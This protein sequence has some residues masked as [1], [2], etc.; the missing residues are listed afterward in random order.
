[1][2]TSGSTI[3]T[4]N[5]SEG[6]LG[7][8]FMTLLP[9]VACLA[10][11]V[12]LVIGLILGGGNG[13]SAAE[14]IDPSPVS[15]Q[16][17]LLN[18]FIENS[19]PDD[20]LSGHAADLTTMTAQLQEIKLKL[21]QNDS[22]YTKVSDLDKAKAIGYI[23]D[24]V[25]YLQQ[26]PGLAT[27][28]KGKAASLAQKFIDEGKLLSALVPLGS[29]QL[30]VPSVNQGDG[31][32]CGHTSAVMVGLYYLHG[33]TSDSRISPYVKRD[34]NDQLI[35][36]R[37]GGYNALNPGFLNEV[38]G[39]SDWE[40]E[41]ISGKDSTPDQIFAMIK[42]SINGGDPVI[43][44]TLGLFYSDD[45]NHIVVITGYDEAQKL[46]IVNNPAVIG[47]KGYGTIKD[48]QVGQNGHTLDMQFV[49]DH[50]GWRHPG[51]HGH[52]FMVRSK[53]LSYL[54]S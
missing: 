50:L 23:D 30:N 16:R 4:S 49:K 2:A 52:S 24:M 37:P 32:W 36:A 6:S 9:Y 13:A 46:I 22:R 17:P 47:S 31:N 28:D 39:Y 48:S 43:L 38:S 3:H 11:P 35:S 19:R 18:T 15:Q 14:K 51:Y 54:N 10:L 20:F 34:G 21:Q 7:G 53:Y 41:N 27:S 40:N 42:A 33:D 29:A 8:L 1:M 25:S 26:I 5:Q 44:Y 12:I 45:T